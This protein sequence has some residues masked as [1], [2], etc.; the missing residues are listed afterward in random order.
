MK[1]FFRYHM[2]KRRNLIPT[3][4]P[5]QTSRNPFLLVLGTKRTARAERRALSS[6]MPIVKWRVESFRAPRYIVTPLGKKRLQRDGMEQEDSGGG[7][8]KSGFFS[9]AGS[10]CCEIRK[11]GKVLLRSGVSAE[12]RHLKKR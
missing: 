3:F 1:H 11:V 8:G 4:Y 10:K 12:R 6:F 2:G 9:E 5:L 7:C